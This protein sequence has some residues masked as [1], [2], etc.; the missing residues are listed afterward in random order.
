MTQRAVRGFY[1]IET[2]VFDLDNTLYPHHLNLWHQVD[3]RIRDYAI[4][5]F[6]TISHEDAF[7]LPE[8]LFTRRYGTTMRGLM[9]EH[10][11]EPD[12]VPGDGPSDRSLRR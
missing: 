4:A 2:W 9:E 11:L 1:G 6:L 7:R 8:G 3:V 12:P 5:D 10:G